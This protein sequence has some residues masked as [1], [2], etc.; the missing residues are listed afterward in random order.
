[1]QHLIVAII[2]AICLYLVIHR[3]ARTISRARK[4]DPR[5]DTCTETNCPL[6]QANEHSSCNCGCKDIQGN[7]H[8]TDI[9]LKNC[10]KTRL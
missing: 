4:G 10:K 7:K 1:M 8:K 2:F 5:C 3:V 6:H 9:N